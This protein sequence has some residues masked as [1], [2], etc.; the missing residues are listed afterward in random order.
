MDASDHARLDRLEAAVRD[1]CPRVTWLE[2]HYDVP[3]SYIE[4]VI[5]KDMDKKRRDSAGAERLREQRVTE[6]YRRAESEAEATHSRAPIDAFV[7]RLKAGDYDVTNDS[8]HAE[9]AGHGE[10][11][12]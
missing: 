5:A 12:S 2:T 1:L 10:A 4:A 3:M 8:T 11:V 7:R 6:A 9:V